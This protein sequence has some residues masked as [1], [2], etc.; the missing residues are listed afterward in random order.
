M[1]LQK[2]LIP[3]MAVIHQNKQKV[4]P[5]L[6]YQDSNDHV[7]PLTARADICT[8]KLREWWRAGSNVSVLDL[9]KAYLQVHMHQSLWSYQTVLFKG[10]R[11]CSTR[12][13]FGL[14]VAPS[15]M[16]TIVDAIL[17]KDKRIR[18]AT[19]AYIDD[20]YVDE[21]ISAAS[22]SSARSQGG[23]RMVR[24]CLGYRSGERITLC[25]GEEGTKSQTCLVSSQDGMYFYYAA[26][27]LGTFPWVVSFV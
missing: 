10:R 26:N 24:E 4:R 2:G 18:Q 22:A 6:D 3:L 9:R 1:G 15:I 5:V 19:S 12:M 13:G 27:W 21:S 25:I 7:D 23:D 11:Y 16:Q 17:T 14:N 20:V 8:K